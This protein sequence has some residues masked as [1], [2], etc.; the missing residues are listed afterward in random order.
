MLYIITCSFTH[1]PTVETYE[2]TLEELA[3]NVATTWSKIPHIVAKFHNA[4]TVEN[5]EGVLAHFKL[6]PRESVQPLPGHF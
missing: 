4:W 2:G 3:R 1:Q 5:D 6:Q